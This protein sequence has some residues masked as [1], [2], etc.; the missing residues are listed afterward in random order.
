MISEYIHEKSL[1]DLINCKQGLRQSY[2]ILSSY[3]QA[4]NIQGY[5]IAIINDEISAKHHKVLGDYKEL[6]NGIYPF[7]FL[8]ITENTEKRIVDTNLETKL[9]E[10]GFKKLKI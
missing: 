1:N 8:K 9:L 5:E 6:S 10:T 3:F 2:E 7:L 4:K